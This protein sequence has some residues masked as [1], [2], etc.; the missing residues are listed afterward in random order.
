MSAYCHRYIPIIMATEQFGKAWFIIVLASLALLLYPVLHQRLPL[1]QR[2]F[3]TYAPFKRFYAPTPLPADS[4][5]APPGITATDTT[6][7]TPM[8]PDTLK[9]Y[10]G[11]HALS[12]FI[13]KLYAGGQ[14]VRIAHFGD[15]SIE[16][17]LI[18]QTLRDSLQHCFGGEGVGL[19]GLTT[20]IKG[21]RRSVNLH[22]VGPWHTA[23][24]EKKASK[25]LPFGL[26]G[27][28]FTRRDRQVPPPDS[29]ALTGAD[30][31]AAPKT[32]PLTTTYIASRTF[33]G[34]S[35]FPRARLFYGPARADS[36]SSSGAAG[37]VWASAGGKEARLRLSGQNK[38]NEALLAGNPCRKMTLAFDIAATQPL[39]GVSFESERGVILDNM[40]LR[41][42]TG[43]WLLKLDKEMLRQFQSLL[44]YDL[45]ILQFGL[46]VLNARM[47]DY[48][49]YTEEMSAVIRHLQAA[50][51]EVPILLIGPSD[52]SMRV[53]GLLQ[54]DPSVPRI[55][56]AQRAA[57]QACGTAFFSMYE[58]MGGDNSMQEWVE[59]SRPALANRDYTHF[60]FEGADK[61][62]GMILSF[63]MAGGQS[64]VLAQ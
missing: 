34:T 64:E 35:T 20:A 10:D 47:T 42:N 51:P 59:Q 13:A 38:V 63:L 30:T 45:I 22:A 27:Q 37:I 41:G 25:A 33:R 2:H 12:S 52:K 21:F 3:K 1:L 58:A 7:S 49:W 6:A 9:T 50:F 15:S 48:G 44:A 46:N 61:M 57:A 23:S 56:A 16:G 11:R 24:L 18:S 26:M 14:Q 62:A 54:T 60:N 28:A 43:A 19:L 8:L 4:T 31:S 39:Y 17:D 53:N 29:L 36:S 32:R 40:P 55:T 5:A